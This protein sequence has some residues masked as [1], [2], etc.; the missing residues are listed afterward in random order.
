MVEKPRAAHSGFE[1]VF[2][3][4]RERDVVR[5]FHETNREAAIDPPIR[6]S[7]Q[8]RLLRFFR[9]KKGQNHEQDEAEAVYRRV[10]GEGRAGSVDGIEDVGQIARAYQVHPVQV[11]QWKGVIREHLPELFEPTRPQARTAGNGSPNSTWRRTG[12]K[13]CRQPGLYGFMRLVA[14][15]DWWRR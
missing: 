15:M 7:S 9:A 2:A 13:K 14:V 3:L 10:Q 12:S 6:T 1:P 8:A 4:P 5:I 11:T